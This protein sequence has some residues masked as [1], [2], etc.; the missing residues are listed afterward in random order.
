MAV[1]GSVVS[2]NDV[3]RSSALGRFIAE[4]LYYE[5]NQ[6]GYPVREYR[7]SNSIRR[8][9]KEGEF[10]LSRAL[11]K[12]TPKASDS[13]VILGTYHYDKDAVFVNARLVVPKSGRVVRTAS[14]VLES[15]DLTR[16]MA[17]GGSRVLPAGSM[18]IRDFRT[19][20]RP[21][22]PASTS[23]FDRGEDIH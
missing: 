9:Q 11:G 10:A 5:W 15:N 17:R 14:L 2:G 22:P 8:R 12:V 23:P 6:R 4:Q 19:A 21:V 13:V 7:L 20:V 1:P 3:C 18:R 16:R